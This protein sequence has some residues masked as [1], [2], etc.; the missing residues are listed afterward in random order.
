METHFILTLSA[1]PPLMKR[2]FTC[3]AVAATLFGCQDQESSAP[4]DFTGNESVYALA[5]PPDG[6]Y[7]ISGTV[8]FKEKKDGQAV[9]VVALSGTDGDVQ[10]P[11]HLHLGNIGAPD[12]DVY[13]LLNPV[14]GKTG[15]SETLL[16][17]AGDE[18]P[19]DY[20][21]LIDLNAC[22][23]VHLAE[24]GPGRDVVLAGGNIGAA[25]ADDASA[26]GA[27]FASCKSE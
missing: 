8:T 11:V 21:K 7:D 6:V 17:R 14:L 18:T 5:A 2:L 3:V 22:I 13:A 23:K 15:L 27:F 19:M 24:S 12:A 10:L 9:I 20:Q 25:F 26:R 1:N 4:S 16:A